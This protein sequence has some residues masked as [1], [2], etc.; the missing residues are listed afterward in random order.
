MN[1]KKSSNLETI[2]KSAA[3]VQDNTCEE[4][5][6]SR[7]ERLS[8]KIEVLLAASDG[9]SVN[10]RQSLNNELLQDNS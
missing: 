7:K 9:K 1:S 4:K 3:T 6:G 8:I 10:G 5:T 2:L